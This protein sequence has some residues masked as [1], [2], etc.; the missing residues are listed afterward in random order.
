MKKIRILLVDDQ[1]L[2]IE[3]LK[4]VLQSRAKDIV[5][6]GVASNGQQAVQLVKE[7]KPDLVLMDVRMPEMD[8]VRS[9]RLIKEM[10]PEIKVIMLTTFDDD[11]FIIEAIR[12]GAVG[13][14]LKDVSPDEL[15]EDIRAICMG[16][17][18]FSPKVVKKIV[19][20]LDTADKKKPLDERAAW[21]ESLTQKE[22]EIL[23]F[24]S[25]GY[26]N[27]EIA[28]KIYMAEQSVRNYVSRIYNKLG[29]KGRA[30][31]MSEA[32]SRGVNLLEIP[33]KD[34][35]GGSIR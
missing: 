24:I 2:F 12:S 35:G 33:K 34:S 25:K 17:V 26:N 14:I 8:G 4:N 3:S 10:N 1:R 28:E 27:Q 19:G 32:I 7:T 22:Q 15:I 9:T 5:I 21:L 6:T 29:L 31:A 23:I 13:Y 16:K 30:Q 11:E 18:L 20:H